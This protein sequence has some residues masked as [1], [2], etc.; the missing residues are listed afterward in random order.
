MNRK[1]FTITPQQ[2]DLLIRAASMAGDEGIL[3][4]S[5]AAISAQAMRRRGWVQLVNQRDSPSAAGYLVF[6]TAEGREELASYEKRAT[7]HHDKLA[8]PEGLSS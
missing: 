4:A 3:V 6:I 2:V 5:A 8:V 1:R 7:K